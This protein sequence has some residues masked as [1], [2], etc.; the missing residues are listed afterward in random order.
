LLASLAALASVMALSLS[1]FFS[2]SSVTF[3]FASVKSSFLVFAAASLVALVAASEAA[4]SLAYLLDVSVV[5]FAWVAFTNSSC[6]YQSLLAFSYFS[7]N[8]VHLLISGLGYPAVSN[9][10]KAFCIY[11]SRVL[12][13]PAFL[14]NYA[15]YSAIS[16]VKLAKS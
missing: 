9:L 16:A 12:S 8:S 3:F 6:L 15:F 11:V 1:L 4:L 7:F 2:F 5:S 13:V 10:S 14:V